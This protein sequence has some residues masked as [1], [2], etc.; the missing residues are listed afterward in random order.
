[1]L[2]WASFQPFLSLLLPFLPPSSI[3]VKYT[4]DHVYTWSIKLQEPCVW[5]SLHSE[6]LPGLRWSTC[7]ARSFHGA[8]WNV[9]GGR[10]CHRVCPLA[11]NITV[12]DERLCCCFLVTCC[13]SLHCNTR[14][15]S[16]SPDKTHN[17]DNHALKIVGVNFRSKIPYHYELFLHLVINAFMLV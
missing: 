1:M 17:H 3:Q 15:L 16:W 4:S 8:Q 14:Q 13:F 7:Q 11:Y 12:S 9:E 5:G 2:A 10:C 6:T